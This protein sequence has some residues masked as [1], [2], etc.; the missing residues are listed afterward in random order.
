MSISNVA[1]QLPPL[2]YAHRH[3]KPRQK[4]TLA[5]ES[6][7]KE[8]LKQNLHVFD[9]VHHG[10]H[11][12]VLISESI[13]SSPSHH[14]L[15]RQGHLCL[16]PGL[17][18][19]EP[20]G[21]SFNDGFNIL[22]NLQ[23]DVVATNVVEFSLPR[24]TVNGTTIMCLN[25][26]PNNSDEGDLDLFSKKHWTLSVASSSCCSPVSAFPDSSCSSSNSAAHLTPCLQD[27]AT[28]VNAVCII[29][30]HQEEHHPLYQTPP[31]AHSAHTR[32]KLGCALALDF[33]FCDTLND[34][35]CFRLCTQ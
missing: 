1:R 23:G 5:V 9:C 29:L 13:C 2:R 8:R 15:H 34:D 26:A 19:I 18:H 21:L 3:Q 16:A 17:S 28:S 6:Y 22:H 20:G 32:S 31:A 14:L 33:L 27:V 25:L 12:L 10:P 11:S 7:N 24:D 30:P 4:A 35:V